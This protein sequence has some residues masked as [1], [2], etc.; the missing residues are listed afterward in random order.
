MSQT[1]AITPC[2]RTSRA[3]CYCCQQNV[4]II[5]LNEHND[6]LNSRL[7]PLVEIMK[8]LGNRIQTIN[9]PKTFSDCHDKLEKWRVESHQNIEQYFEQKCQNLN[10]IIM[11]K[12]H[13]QQEKI[14]HIQ[15]RIDELVR[16]Q[17]VTRQDI[18]ELTTTIDHLEKEMNNMEEKFLEI[19][20]QSLKLDNNL[21][22]IRGI[23][24]E[25][26]DL[27]VLSSA[28]KIINL[29][30]GSYGA[31]A[32]ND[33]YLLIHQIP[34]LCLIGQDLII[35][36]RISW[37]NGII[38]DMCWSIMLDRFIIIDEKNIFLLD[39]NNMSIEKIKTIEKR[40]WMS[41]A[42][43]EK[44]LFL[45]TNEWGSSIT[46]INL[47]SSKK[48]SNQWQSPNI[49]R[50]DEY[51]DIITYNNNKLAMIIRNSSTNTIRI[52]LRSSESLDCIWILPLDIVWNPRQPFYCCSFVGEDW[53][54]ADYETGRLLHVTKAGRLKSV[55]PYNTI[56][57]CVTLF[58]SNMLAVSTKNAINF[59][60]LNHKKSY[61]IFVL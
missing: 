58:G 2:N 40:K 4:C 52:E 57:Y 45:S 10:Q 54:V 49:C 11:E 9:V 17:Q 7:N 5:H 43:S 30:E 61:T 1:C 33:Q 39:I 12:I 37:R 60:E 56:P 34:N 35:F 13:E 22:N 18:Y 32:S 26:Y 36:K 50:K 19:H 41:C 21:I 16:E 42:C 14:A 29:P 6:I 28:Y 31:M 51:I 44:F 38:Y 47:D 23:N 24:E 25:E 48:F 27:S 8:T 55:L 3:L 46:K 15:F 59:H 20:I 53:L